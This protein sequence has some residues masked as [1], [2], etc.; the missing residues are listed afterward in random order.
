MGQESYYEDSND[1]DDGVPDCRRSGPPEA[2]KCSIRDGDKEKRGLAGH[3]ALTYASGG[4]LVT[5]MGHWIELT[6]IN[7]SEDA[8]I[9]VAQHNFGDDEFNELQADLNCQSTR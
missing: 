3:V 5:S 6:R 7:T 4:Q 8:V 9:R 2:V 1:G